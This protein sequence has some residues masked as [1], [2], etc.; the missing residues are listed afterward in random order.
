MDDATLAE[1]RV[2]R[3]IWEK[4]ADGRF[5]AGDAF[6]VAA[7]IGGARDVDGPAGSDRNIEGA[8]PDPGAAAFLAELRGPVAGPIEE[9]E[10]SVLGSAG[11]GGDEDRSVG[12]HRQPPTEADPDAAVLAERG[13]E[14]SVWQPP[15]DLPDP[16][17]LLRHFPPQFDDEAAVALQISGAE[18]GVGDTGGCLREDLP[19]VA[20]AAIE[21]PRPRGGAQGSRWHACAERQG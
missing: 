11:S 21:R 10:R 4:A 12:P 1:A 14:F 2:R 16:F 7:T 8:E 3:A 18:P 6:K 17:L 15:L 5:V 20:E 9:D 19:A 13:I